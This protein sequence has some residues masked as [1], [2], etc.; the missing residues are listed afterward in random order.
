MSRMDNWRDKTPLQRSKVS[1]KDLMRLIDLFVQNKSP[2]QASDI[3]NDSIFESSLN[4]N[5]I[6]RY[7]KML[8]RIAFL[9]Y[10]QKLHSIL[11][12]GEV[13]VDETVVFKPKRTY[14]RR[15]RRYKLRNMWLLGMIERGSKRFVII[16]IKNRNETTL[17]M[18]ILKFV[19][20]NATIFTDCHSVYVN[21]RK[22]PKE[23]RVIAYGYNHQYIDHS[24]EFVSSHFQHIHTNTIER[25][26]RSVKTDL[27]MK[28]VT[29]GYVS[30]IAR[31]YFHKTLTKEEQIK[32]I[33][34]YIHS[35]YLD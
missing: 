26:W 27:R 28:K 34:N 7:F 1:Y 2:S 23:S 10:Q 24:E 5:T 17:M 12:D 13:E 16:P 9:Y 35:N 15:Y 4:R 3:F 6:S 8:G 19:N 33:R 29:V 11:L 31:Y 21:N 25:L 32:Y 18:S 14:A 22:T 20:C 30:A